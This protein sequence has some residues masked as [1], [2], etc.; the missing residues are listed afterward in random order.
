[1]QDTKDRPNVEETYT[2]A[3]SASNLRFETRDG[4]PIGASGLLIAAAWSPSRLGA[5]LMRLHSEW[6][7]CAKPDRPTAELINQLALTVPDALKASRSGPGKVMVD[8]KLLTREAWASMEAHRWY[9]Q[10][11]RMLIGRLKTL[12]DA[13]RELAI[14]AVKWRIYDP[15]PTAGAVIKYWLDQT[16]NTCD[17]LKWKKTAGAPSLSNRVCHACGGTGI[18]QPPHG[19]EGRRLLNYMDDCVSRARASIQSRLGQMRKPVT[20]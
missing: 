15:I 11:L 9:E 6:D 16:C 13:R 2:E 7:G 5:Q 8:G 12:P 1:M 3:V 20:K 18:G 19:D 10:E 14:Q 4:S 17:G